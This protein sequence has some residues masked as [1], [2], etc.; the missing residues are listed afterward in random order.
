[1]RFASYPLFARKR[2]NMC[3]NP[4]KICMSKYFK[5]IEYP[6]PTDVIII[7]FN[8]WIVKA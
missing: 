3:V 7:S 2:A 4:G 5:S 8:L 1:M 6:L